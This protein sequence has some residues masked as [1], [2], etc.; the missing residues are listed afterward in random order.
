[1]DIPRRSSVIRKWQE[2]GG[3]FAAVFP[4]HYPRE[5][6][7]AH[8]LLPVEVWGPPGVDATAA[9]AHLQTY[10]CPIVHH[11]LSFI[12]SGAL[13]EAAVIVVPHGCDSLQGLG[14][15]LVDFFE[16]R[17]PKVLPFY[18]PR[19]ERLSD[20]E[21]L[22]RELESL[23][24][25]IAE[26]LD[27]SPPSRETLAEAL[28]REERAD[29]LLGD[30]HLRKARLGL[31]DLEFY[32][33][34]RSREHLPAEQFVD[35]GTPVLEQAKEREQATSRVPIILSGILPEP[36]VGLFGALEEMGATVVADDLACSGRRLYPAGASEEP[37]RRMAERILGGP[38]DPM[39]GSAI[40]ERVRHLLT[41]A[42]RAG[43]RGFV[44]YDVKF[45]EPELFD[46]PLV[47][48]ALQEG[49]YPSLAVEVEL[50]KELPHQ[51]ITRLEAF[52]EM[53]GATPTLKRRRRGGTE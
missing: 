9:S 19:S 51:T 25:R 52:I 40:G 33:L 1:M 15:I 23:S 31:S 17:T 44:F 12:L 29:E 43:A 22:A 28:R 2:G 47:R 46:L 11:G 34:A 10:A 41:L 14:S 7:R 53:L 35:L 18:L 16:G 45:C 4:I 49:G 24:S 3:R 5:L 6:F 32:R 48:E 38:P 20:L 8:G 42:K 26:A 21:Y 13:D 30:L 36:M 37:F 27:Q 39:R 50:A